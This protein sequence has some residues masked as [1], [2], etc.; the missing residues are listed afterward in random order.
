MCGNDRV[1]PEAVGS[2]R[3]SSMPGP[4]ASR[5]VG[6]VSLAGPV[7]TC[8]L[9]LPA[10]RVPGADASRHVRFCRRIDSRR[11]LRLGDARADSESHA[12]TRR[13]RLGL[14]GRDE[15]RDSEAGI[16]A[17]A[18][19]TRHGGGAGDHTWGHAGGRLVTGADDTTP[20]WDRDPGHEH[21]GSG[22]GHGA[23]DHASAP[24][25]RGAGHAHGHAHGGGVR[26]GARHAG[27]LRLS[28]L[29]IVVFLVVQVVVGILADSLALLSDAGH[30]ATDALGMGM[31]IAAISAASR[32]SQADH[33]TF[34]LY[35]LEILAAL[36]NA[37]LLFAVG[38]Y[39]LYEAVL[40]FA[41]RPAHRHHARA[42]RRRARP[43]RQRG[44]VPAPAARCPGEPQPARA[45]TS[46]CS[47]TCSARSASSWPRS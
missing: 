22:H 21:G 45:R 18:S 34:G 16:G 19:V 31:A 42:G 33:R 44:L 12:G 43:A 37:V 8:R 47:A 11:T 7:S 3:A 13:T 30:M 40:R 6:D 2:N 1:A 15:A 39:V 32:Q 36:A 14:G 5:I 20:R 9:P 46:R 4:A 28:F 23:E 17:L 27:R 29:L 25:A 35:R 38:G 24:A 10:L 41:R 26:A